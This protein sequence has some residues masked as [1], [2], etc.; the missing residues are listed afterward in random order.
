MGR[1]F[2]LSDVCNIQVGDRLPQGFA[3]LLQTD[4]SPGTTGCSKY[5]VKC[6]TFLFYSCFQCELQLCGKLTVV[7]RAV[8]MEPRLSPFGW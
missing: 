5:Q 6:K 4:S 1:S 8:R 7:S 3:A 2:D